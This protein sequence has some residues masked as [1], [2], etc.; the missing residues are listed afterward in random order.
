[1]L[2]FDNAA[3]TKIDERIISS[4]TKLL[5]D[6][7]ANSSSLHKEGRK[8]AE[9]LNKSREIISSLLNVKN[10][11]II[12]TNGASESN[13][14]ALKGVA[15]KYSNRGKHIISSKVE[16]PSILNCLKQLESEGYEITLLDVNEKGTIN[17]DNVISHL[18]K[19]TILVSLMF[20]NNETGSIN[21]IE[22]I[23][24]RIKQASKT[25]LF[26]CDATQGIG[27]IPLKLD[28]VDLL[29]M[30]GHKIYGLKGTGVLVKKENISLEPLIAGGS[31]EYSLRAGTS[32]YA[33]DVSLAKA[34]KIA[35]E[36][37]KENFIHV[38]KLNDIV[39]DSLPN[40]VEVNSPVDGSPYILNLSFKGKKSA[41]VSTFFENNDICVSTVS[42]CGSQTNSKS[43]V[44]ENIFKDEER[45][46]SSVRISF[47]K[48]NTEDEAKKLIE[49]I[50]KVGKEIL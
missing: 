26:H 19:D 4:Y 8:A 33:G 24:K 27:K 21:N 49:V 7:Y 11:E 34:I 15:H 10:D 42:A 41:I 46:K 12:F 2:Y 13:N 37:Q 18:R 48:Y 39:R 50:Q 32:N 6:V 31:Q 43:Y 30:S 35:F 29:S 22:E 20:V 40:D 36:E 3:T 14:L 25:T 9:L 16:H 38:K 28:N 44:I 5:N 45:A 47:S 1:M 23:S 17:I